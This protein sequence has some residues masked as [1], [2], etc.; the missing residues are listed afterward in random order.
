M[1]AEVVVVVVVRLEGVLHEP[2]QAAGAPGAAAASGP[3]ALFHVAGHGPGEGQGPAASAGSARLRV[4]EGGL[5]GGASPGR[6]RR[7][8]RRP[9]GGGRGGRGEGS[10]RRRARES[11]RARPLTEREPGGSARGS[12]KRAAASGL[13]SGLF[14]TTPFPSHRSRKAAAKFPRRL[15]VPAPGGRAQAEPS[16]F[17]PCWKSWSLKKNKK[18]YVFDMFKFICS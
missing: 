5:E 7:R 3:R 15:H 2:D 16:P 11:A 12:E 6:R 9:S 17:A 18:L 4:R 10:G 14:C 1:G 8:S 13:S